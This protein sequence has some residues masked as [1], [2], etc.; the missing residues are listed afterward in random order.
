V[1]S[2]NLSITK[3]EHGELWRTASRLVADS[4]LAVLTT[5]DLPSGLSNP[6]R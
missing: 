2:Q 4:T 5:A 6:F 3:G 1:S